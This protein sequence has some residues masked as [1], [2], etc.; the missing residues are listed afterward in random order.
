MHNLELTIGM[1]VAFQM[2]RE[3]LSVRRMKTMRQ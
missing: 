3:R 2:F 1:L